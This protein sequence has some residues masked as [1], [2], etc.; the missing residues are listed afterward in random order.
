MAN[1]SVHFP[2]E[3]TGDA[4]LDKIQENVRRALEAR[5]VMDTAPGMGTGA[6]NKIVR[7]TVFSSAGPVYAVKVV[8]NLGR[9][10]SG[11]VP[12][13]IVATGAPAEPFVYYEI[14]RTIEYV[15]VYSEIDAVVDWW[16]F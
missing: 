1:S 14:E 16:C 12:V 7:N 15:S 5:D 10:P 6:N 3:R 13:R 4:R 2:R 11:L 9:V 8:H